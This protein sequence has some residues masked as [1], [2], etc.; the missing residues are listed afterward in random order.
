MAEQYHRFGT[1]GAI[2]GPLV[3]RL[4]LEAVAIRGEVTRVTLRSLD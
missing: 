1:W 2:L 3:V 4:W